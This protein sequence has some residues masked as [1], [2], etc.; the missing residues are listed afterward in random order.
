MKDVF[1]KILC[2]SVS[3]IIMG[4]L[5]ACGAN[6]ETAEQHG[7]TAAMGGTG[8][9][10]ADPFGKYDPAITLTTV[11][12]LTDNITFLQGE[13]IDNNNWTKA[14]MNHLGIKIENIWMASSNQFN[15]KL[16]V[17][18][19]SGDIP[20]FFQVSSTQFKQLVDNDMLADLK[21]VYDQYAAPF[22]KEVMTAAGG[23][24]MKSMQ[25]DGKQYGLACD[26]PCI[27]TTTQIW[28]RSD[29][30][31]KVNLSAPKTMDDVLRIAEAFTTQDPNSNNKNDT[32]GLAFQKDLFGQWF[33]LDGFMNG[34]HA[35]PTI[36]V[37]DASGKIQNGAIQPEVKTALGKL[38]E[39]YRAKQIDPEFGV[40]DATKT[41]EDIVAGKVGMYYACFAT[42]LWPLGDSM[43]KEPNADWKAY[44]IVS[45]DAQPALASETFT[46][47][48]GYVVS[49]NCK[50]PEG[51]IKLLN[52]TLKN[53]W[54]P[55]A[56]PDIYNT[57]ENAT[58]F[59]SY[60]PIYAEPPM[61]NLDAGIAVQEAM[62]SNDPS[63]LNGEQKQYYNA[64][65][66]YRDNKDLASWPNFAIFGT[67]GGNSST[68][69][70]NYYMQNKLLLPD[71][72]FGI[73]TD[74][75]VDKKPN[76]DKLILET[77]TQIIM[78]QTPLDSFDKFVDQWRQIG[79]DTITKE[80]N[81]WAASQK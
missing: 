25:I 27:Q 63:K 16:N 26:S 74:N 40:K 57:D 8:A 54:S 46:A 76:M 64:A 13:D 48:S 66:A 52:E 50:N 43:K 24:A 78:G 21:D 17:T 72:F 60:A 34:Y 61:K 45:A 47:L 29:W 36:W 80:V 15:D 4:S 18:I 23:Y 39:M 5:V 71:E 30:L 10:A 32:Y 19:A 77:Y 58:P 38:T 51:V 22:T 68:E 44:P 20:D 14:Y 2:I 31:K 65:I 28:I 41:T 49:K 81:D 42:P 37:K 56:Q 59:W 1:K 70:E 6:T 62:K 69:V 79:G 35:Y 33:S 53:L 73:P 75:M 67:N 7:T 9:P 12:A 11:R 55:E 3:L